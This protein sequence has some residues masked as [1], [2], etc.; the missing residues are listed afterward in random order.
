[1]SNQILPT[2]VALAAL[3]S[4]LP[5]GMLVA[6]EPRVD[7]EIALE[8]GSVPTEARAWSEMLSKAGFS[9]VRIR[10]DKGDSPSLET[11]GTAQS[12]VYKVIGILTK[13]NQLVVPRGQFGLI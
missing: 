6:A 7:L 10:S 11:L 8:G 1:M 12:P 5:A 4:G 2:F 3:I 9:S 13:A